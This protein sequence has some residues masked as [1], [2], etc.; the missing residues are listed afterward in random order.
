MRARRGP[1]TAAGIC[2][3]GE[4]FVQGSDRR[5]RADPGVIVRGREPDHVEAENLSANQGP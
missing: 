4:D 2:K 5:E 1:G 3:R